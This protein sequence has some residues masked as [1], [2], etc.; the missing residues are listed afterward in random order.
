MIVSRARYDMLEHN[1]NELIA[2]LRAALAMWNA[3]AVAAEARADQFFEAYRDLRMTHGANPAPAPAPAVVTHTPAT[4]AVP[5]AIASAIMV[6]AKN[7]VGLRRHY[8]EY[9]AVQRAAG[10]PDQDIADEILE[11]HSDDNEGIR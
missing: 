3:R 1:L 11:G 4:K 8:A 6:R 5:D 9:V 10:I 7:S 2:Q